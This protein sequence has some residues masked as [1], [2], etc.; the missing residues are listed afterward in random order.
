MSDWKI[1]LY[2]IYQPS[3]ESLWVTPNRIWNNSFTH[4]KDGEG[5]HPSIVGRLFPSKMMC[6]IIPGISKDFNKDTDVF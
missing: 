2:E 6:W 3:I 4:N 1:T 5:S